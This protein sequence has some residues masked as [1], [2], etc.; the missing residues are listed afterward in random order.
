LVKQICAEKFKAM[1]ASASDAINLRLEELNALN[2]FPVPDGDTGANMN[3]TLKA[4]CAALQNTLPE[5]VG[6]AA[7]IAANA[8]LSAA[9]G[10]SGMILALLFRGIAAK[11]K[12]FAEADAPAFAG[13][14]MEGVGMAYKSVAN[15]VEGTM[16]TVSRTAA[17][18]AVRFA[19]DESDIEAVLRRAIDAGYRELERT[20][21]TNPVL[22]KAGVV[23]AGAKGWL[24]ILDGMLAALRGM[25]ARES[26]GMKR[27]MAGNSPRVPDQGIVFAYC[28]EFSADKRSG[29]DLSAFRDFLGEMGDSLIVVEDESAVKIHIHTNNP[30]T[31]LTEALAYTA[32][33]TAKIEDM[34]EQHTQGF[35]ALTE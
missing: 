13:A 24:C 10:N 23:D 4:G 25:R 31:V 26:D 33:L 5:T 17:S 27:S 29:A 11:L 12:E 16:L 28:T 35:L 32:R 15:P 22:K 3:A 21:E 7:G 1:V 20:R 6:R 34:R 8:L 14:L 19:A 2:V 30:A 18:E 9:R